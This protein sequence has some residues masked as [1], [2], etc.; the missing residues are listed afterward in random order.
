MN[1]ITGL[2][3]QEIQLLIHIQIT[4]MNFPILQLSMPG[5]SRAMVLKSEGC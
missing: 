2:R 3:E 1:K 5:H 4:I